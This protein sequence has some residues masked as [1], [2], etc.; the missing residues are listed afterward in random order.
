M[1]F[2]RHD[3]FSYRTMYSSLIMDSVLIKM[4]LLPGP[5]TVL[6]LVADLKSLRASLCWGSST[7]RAGH[8]T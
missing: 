6:S 1:K 2:R 3:Q 7:P 5:L 8:G 4:P